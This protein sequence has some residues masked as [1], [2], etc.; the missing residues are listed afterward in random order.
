MVA[1]LALAQAISA[2][3]KAWRTAT[4]PGQKFAAAVLLVT[5]VF[6]HPDITELILERIPLAK[7]IQGIIEN[8]GC[9]VAGTPV[10]TADGIKLI[11]QVKVGDIV[12]SRNPASGKNGVRRVL[13]T[14]KRLVHQTVTIELCTD[15]G[16]NGAVVETLIGTTEHPFF[17]PRGQVK[18]GDLGVGTEILTRAGPSQDGQRLYVKEIKREAYP[19]GI[20]V[21]NFVVDGDHTYFVGLADGG[22]WVHNAPCFSRDSNYEAVD[23]SG[24]TKVGGVDKDISRRVWQRQDIDWARV[25]S[26]GL[27]NQQRCEVGKPPIVDVGIESFII[28]LHHLT[29]N[30]PGAMLEILKKTHMDYHDQLH[31]TVE[32]G[33]SFRNDP[34]L[35]KQYNNFRRKY[36]I[37]RSQNP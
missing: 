16:G 9:F 30:E 32:D 18:M 11:Q 33:D 37:W 35:E 12:Y 14:S 34:V 3:E 26:N 29:Q 22:E 21:Y 25:D 31:G 28:E 36:W 8:I 10:Q 13:S 15:K 20:Y 17:T 5:A 7:R 19:G 23:Y 4:T 6:S 2:N 1:D 27:T 24:T